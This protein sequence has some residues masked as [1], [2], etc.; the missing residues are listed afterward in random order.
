MY[1]HNKVIESEADSKTFTQTNSERWG[2]IFS[3]LDEL[4]RVADSRP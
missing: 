2:R 4:E 1:I 3:K